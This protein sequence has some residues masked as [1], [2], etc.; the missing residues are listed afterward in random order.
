METALSH[1]LPDSLVELI[2]EPRAD[3][4]LEAAGR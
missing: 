2:A 4:I 3:A 1:P